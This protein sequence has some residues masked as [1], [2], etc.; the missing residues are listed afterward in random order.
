MRWYL[1]VDTM[2]PIHRATAPASPGHRH[3]QLLL[4]HP[5]LGTHSWALD[6]SQSLFYF[7]P[8]SV[9]LAR[10][11]GTHSTQLGIVSAPTQT[12]NCTQLELVVFR[13]CHRFDCT[14]DYILTIS[15]FA[16]FY[17]R[18]LARCWPH[19]NEVYAALFVANWNSCT[20]HLESLPFSKFHIAGIAALTGQLAGRWSIPLVTWMIIAIAGPS[21]IPYLPNPIPHRPLSPHPSILPNP[22]PPHPSIVPPPTTSAAPTIR[23]LCSTLHLD[24]SLPKVPIARTGCEGWDVTG[25]PDN[26]EK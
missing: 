24:P 2:T 8:Q 21:P 19:D 6:R 17:L 26:S 10:L 18:P 5:L 11:L 13:K 7:V 12:R 23:L 22:I 4:G 1:S 25:D 20:D 16:L 15:T 9:K 3:P 14:I